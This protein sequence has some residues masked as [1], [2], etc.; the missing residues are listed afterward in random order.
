MNDS[1][2]F[3]DDMA[4]A[5]GDKLRVQVENQNTIICVYVHSTLTV[6]FQLPGFN[7]SS[8]GD[9]INCQNRRPSKIDIPFVVS[10]GKGMTSF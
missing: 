5:E 10:I 2:V 3:N 9:I 7:N 1:G 6:G 4:S 8:S